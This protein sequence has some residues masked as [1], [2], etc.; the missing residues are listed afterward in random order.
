MDLGYGYNGFLGFT[1]FMKD[2]YRALEP[3]SG[4]EVLGAKSCIGINRNHQ[5]RVHASHTA[6]TVRIITLYRV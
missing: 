6:I 4:Y 5:Q 1:R 3:T 2:H